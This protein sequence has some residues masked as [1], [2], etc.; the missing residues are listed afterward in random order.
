M[1]YSNITA[2]FVGIGA[3]IFNGFLF[4]TQQLKN[5]KNLHINEQINEQSL[6][7]RDILFQSGIFSVLRFFL[8]FVLLLSFVSILKINMLICLLGFLISFWSYI[9]VLLRKN[10]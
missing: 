4:F 3:G 2:F 9:F 8:F 10:V 6:N 1:F 5:Y 7:K